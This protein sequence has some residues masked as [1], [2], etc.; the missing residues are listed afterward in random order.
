MNPAKEQSYENHTRLLPIHH[1]VLAPI[2]LIAFITAVV[3]TI[4]SIGNGSL[5]MY[6]ILIL[7]LAFMTLLLGFIARRN[8]LVVQDRVIRVEEQLRH[9][10]LTN[11]PLDPRLTLSQLIALRFAS[12][13]EFPELAAKAAGEGMSPKEIKKAVRK[14]RPDLHRV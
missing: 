2:S 9:Y 7:A 13:E 5:S 4:Q 8:G 14:W 6:P 3:Y 12:D 11:K 1:F 10:M